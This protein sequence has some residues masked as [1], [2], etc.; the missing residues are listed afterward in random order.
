M[1]RIAGHNNE[2]LKRLVRET[3][4]QLR[5]FKHPQ[6]VGKKALRIYGLIEEVENAR[7]RMIHTVTEERRR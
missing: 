4:T 7:H 6:F 1:P 3:G 5:F 2:N